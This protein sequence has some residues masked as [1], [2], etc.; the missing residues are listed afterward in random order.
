ML[1]IA[2]EQEQPNWDLPTVGVWAASLRIA[3]QFAKQGRATC[4]LTGLPEQ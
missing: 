1:N 2:G 3:F 4:M